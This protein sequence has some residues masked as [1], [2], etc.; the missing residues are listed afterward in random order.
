MN[1]VL[2]VDTNNRI[3]W[4]QPGVINLDLSKK[5]QPKGSTSPPTRQ[6]NRSAR[7]AAMSPTI[8]EAP[9]ASPTAS[10]MPTSCRWKSYCPTGS[11]RAR[12]RRGRDPGLDLRGAFVGSEGTLGIATKIGV[13]ITPNAPAVRTLL[14]SF[15]T[16]RDAAQTVS[17]IIAAGVVPAA[18]EVMDQRMTVAVENYVAAGYPTDAAAVLLA[19]VEG[20][21]GGVEIDAARIEELGRANSAT[22]VRLAGS[23]EER[24]ALWKGRK[25]AFGAVAQIAPDYY[26]HDTVVPR[27][28]LAD[29]LE[30]IYE[31]TDRHEVT[32]MNVFHAGDGNLHPLLVFDAREE[33]TLERVHAAGAEI[34]RASLAAGGVLSGEHGI[35]SRS[36]PIWTNSSPRPTSTTRTVFAR[37]STP[38]AGRTPA[39]SCRWDTVAPTS[40]RCARCPPGFGDEH[41]HLHRPGSARLRCAGRRRGPHRRGGQP[42]PLASRRSTRRIGPARQGSHWHRRLPALGDGGHRPR[43][44]DR[45]RTPRNTRRC[46]PD[47]STARPGR[48]RGGAVAV[49][50]NRLDRL[51]RGSA[52]DA[53]LQVRYVSAE[54][55]IVTGGGPVVKNVSGFN[56]PKLIVGSLGTL[57]LIAEVVLRTNPL[58]PVQRW[59]RAERVDPRDIRDALLRPGAVLWDGTSSWALVEGHEVDVDA[60]VDKLATLADIAD[61]DGPPELPPHRWFLSLRGRRTSTR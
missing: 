5:L 20:L 2:S 35:G 61:V 46:R 11:R 3:A 1:K 49:G 10:P 32:V 26:L 33:G 27:A 34:L 14:L 47:L 44:H 12:R 6:A 16:V 40:K 53:V 30:Q 31:I 29:I 15:A 50:E 51:G 42:H 4:V 38:P 22:D 48:H 59:I 13:R 23:E 37:P 21:E 18:L 7:S 24:A 19:E 60:E 8:P 58:P 28:Q 52:R 45:R 54:G 41:A 25:T 39:R 17:D 36:R 57:G 9:T 43:R 56:L 55:E